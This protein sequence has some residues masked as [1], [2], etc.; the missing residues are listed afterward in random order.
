METEAF[1]RGSGLAKKW[2]KRKIIV[3]ANGKGSV[4]KGETDGKAAKTFDC[5]AIVTG[6]ACAK[7]FKFPKSVPVATVGVCTK[8]GK[9]VLPF[10][11]E[12][13][14]A[15]NNWQRGDSDAAEPD[16]QAAA[17]VTTAATAAIPAAASAD[18]TVAKG[19]GK[20]K[21][22]TEAKLKQPKVKEAKSKEKKQPKSKQA[23][24]EAS[25][26]ATNQAS[27]AS[28]PTG[29][30]PR[31]SDTSVAKRLPTLGKTAEY[32]PYENVTVKPRLRGQ[33]VTIR[34]FISST[35]VDTHSE[36]DT[37]IRKVLPSLN[38]ILADR[39]VQIV[40]VDL[41]WGVSSAESQAN[42][43]Q[44]TCLDEIDRCRQDPHEMPWFLGLRSAR[45]GWVQSEF[46]APGDFVEPKRFGWMDPVVKAHPKGISITSMEVW[47]AVLGPELAKI[48][49]PHAFFAFRDTGFTENVADD[50]KWIFDFE[51]RPEDAN[52][53]EAVEMQYTKTPE[54]TQ[55]KD[56]FD[57]I[58]TQIR[59]ATDR[60][61][62]FD[63]TPGEPVVVKETGRLPNGKR[64]G[65][66]SVSGLDYFADKIFN[67]LYAA[68][69]AEYPEYE[70]PLDEHESN[71][72]QQE[73]QARKL[74]KGFVGRT[75][76]LTTLKTFIASDAT[77]PLVVTGPAGIGKSALLSKLANDL[78][79]D[80]SADVVTLFVGAN[81]DSFLL[82][83]VL[84]FLTLSLNKVSLRPLFLTE[85]K[86]SSGIRS[87]WVQLL[88]ACAERQQS[89]DRV[90]VILDGLQHLSPADN[91][92]ALDWLPKELSPHVKLIVS[93]TETHATFAELGRR[94]LTCCKLQPLPK[95]EAKA[96]VRAFLD[97]YHKK[98]CEDASNGLLGDQM[99]VLMSKEEADTPLYLLSAAA[100]LVS[101]GVYEQVTPY[102]KSLPHSFGALFD[103]IL[104]RLES[105]HG[106]EFVRVVLS[107][108]AVSERGILEN[109]LVQMVESFAF[110]QDR[111][112][113]FAR[114]YNSIQVFV[115]AGAPGVLRVVYM[116]IREAIEK[117]Y[118]GEQATF[119]RFHNDLVDYYT[120]IADPDGDASFSAEHIGSMSALPAHVLAAKG[121]SGLAE[122]F[123]SPG[124]LRAKLAAEGC[125]S[126]VRDLNMLP[127]RG[128]PL[129]RQ[130]LKII[131]SNFSTLNDDPVTLPFYLMTRLHLLKDTDSAVKKLYDECYRLSLEYYPASSLGFKPI[132]VLDE[133]EM[134]HVDETHD[135]GSASTGGVLPP[136]SLGELHSVKIQAGLMLPIITPD[137]KRVFAVAGGNSIQSW[138]LPDVSPSI[139]TTIYGFYCT[140]GTATKDSTKVL[141]CPGGAFS[142]ANPSAEGRV[143][144]ANSGSLLQS[145]DM[146]AAAMTH[147]STLDDGSII[148]ASFD[149]TI[150]LWS[151]DTWTCTQTYTQHSAPVLAVSQNGST[152]LSVDGGENVHL[153]STSDMKSLGKMDG[154]QKALGDISAMSAGGD[155]AMISL[156]LTCVLMKDAKRC[157]LAGCHKPLKVYELPSFTLLSQFPEGEYATTT[158]SQVVPLSASRVAVGDQNEIKVYDI[159]GWSVVQVLTGHSAHADKLAVLSDRSLLVS[160]SHDQTLKVWGVNVAGEAAEVS[161]ESP[162]PNQRARDVRYNC[163]LT[164]DDRVLG[165]HH[166]GG[167]VRVGDSEPV[168][169]PDF[170]EWTPPF[171][172][173]VQN[174]L[175]L[176]NGKLVL[177]GSN[178]AVL[179]DRD[180][181]TCEATLA[182]LPYVILRM[183]L[184][185]DELL[186]LA[187]TESPRIVLVNPTT[188]TELP[189]QWD[190]PHKK[191]VVGMLRDGEGG[192]WTVDDGGSCFHFSS[193]GKQVHQ[194][195]VDTGM[196]ILSFPELCSDPSV[197]VCIRGID[198]AKVSM[199]DGSILAKCSGT[200]SYPDRAMLTPDKTRYLQYNATS[201]TVVVLDVELFVPLMSLTTGIA[202]AKFDIAPSGELVFVSTQGF[203]SIKQASTRATRA[204]VGYLRGEQ[205]RKLQESNNDQ[206]A[207]KGAQTIASK[208]AASS[209]NSQL[210]KACSDGDVEKVES[211]L[212]AGVDPNIQDVEFGMAA[213]HT[214][215]H[216]KG[217]GAAAIVKLLLDA[218]ADV[219]AKNKITNSTP[220]HSA[221]S[222]AS[223]ASGPVVKA[224]IDAGSDIEHMDTNGY[225]CIDIAVA[226]KNCAAVKFLLD[227]GA[228]PNTGDSV[229]GMLPLD[230]IHSYLT[231]LESSEEKDQKEW[232]AL[233]DVRE[234][235]LA[236]GAK[237][238]TEGLIPKCFK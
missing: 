37:L 62:S 98:L 237:A 169:L 36:R 82:E 92:H 100:E 181:R 51:Y 25:Q 102:L 191:N 43:I 97:T 199:K 163:V 105:D 55:Y 44:R 86:L 134:E 111:K 175:A 153:W 197:M 200:G 213:L 28:T 99:A 57:T 156:P 189:S 184:I 236:K 65:T 179:V 207:G 205:Q 14:A 211:L 9:S 42:T 84:R 146:H 141:L 40:P 113:T 63:Y 151:P 60:A 3:D 201:S 142:L 53:P 119:K 229:G 58:T 76:D 24:A 154:D 52:L 39:D 174:A 168:D 148:S 221:C 123:L 116:P 17:S 220:L 185:H 101:F 143:Y 13:G 4:Y 158:F 88:E 217:D 61:V 177:G 160:M 30:V 115:T 128:Y 34:L 22:V 233:V 235:L 214:V 120:S 133:P 130:L 231:G 182:S 198:Y 212:A 67:L 188:M 166:T 149:K 93:T 176:S 238:N 5:D 226:T 10:Y 112:S 152:V 227:A 83:Q 33:L 59:A 114:L 108:I 125:G 145:I 23:K 186:M 194:V 2:K 18:N 31:S 206:I 48:E 173:S 73:L 178:S 117:R 8:K 135:E 139:D 140:C 74:R 49:Q 126:L 195:T 222:A 209:M 96:L 104:G 196:G 167:R 164:L 64:F 155:A 124:F 107:F 45:Y 122:L 165:F 223:A 129:V 210:T 172:S 71:A 47:H 21:P 202:N 203:F 19:K 69:D 171:Y 50:W 7:L 216:C 144:D 12:E 81:K 225:H 215:A 15:V 56:D 89:S 218:G 38:K 150:K 70:T 41:R 46:N 180:C 94:S 159:D 20:Q 138:T 183:A 35:F 121:E 193:K 136:P 6:E 219:H 232:D 11:L 161:E 68:I 224:L 72:V 118:F 27:Q 170:K 1:I 80:E 131:N 26:A 204:S 192:C 162:Q 234:A 190:I 127:K 90:V 75:N 87:S 137:A 109:D 29:Q 132:E 187:V 77:T 78:S 32:H 79:T 54:Y 106:E 110:E 157:I 66:G 228:N 85:K 103:F 91:A 230:M 147:V 95:E 208:Q 16:T